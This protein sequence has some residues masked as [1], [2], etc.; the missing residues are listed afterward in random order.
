MLFVSGTASIV[1]HETLHAGDVVAQTRETLAK[2]EAVFAEA[3]RVSR[4]G[5]RHRAASL[6]VYVRHPQDAARVRR[7][8][9]AALGPAADA[10][11]LRADICRHDLLVEIEAIAYADAAGGRPG[12]RIARIFARR[13]RPAPASRAAIALAIAALACAAAHG[14]LRDEPLWEA[15]AGLAALYLPDYRGASQGRVYALPV[16]YFVYRGDFLKADRHGVRGGAFRNVAPNSTCRSAPRFPWTIAQSERGRHAQFAPDRGTGCVARLEPVASQGPACEGRSS[17][18][19]RGAVT[20][21]WHAR[22]TGARFRRHLN[23][24]VN[25]VAEFGGRTWASSAARCTPTGATTVSLHGRRRTWSATRPA[26][27]AR[28]GYGGVQ[29]VVALSRRFRD[30]GVGAYVRHDTPRGAVY[31]SYSPLWVA[32]PPRA[33]WG[34]HGVSASAR[35][36]DALRGSNRPCPCCTRQ[37]RSRTMLLPRS[38]FPLLVRCASCGRRVPCSWSCRPPGL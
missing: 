3:N 13:V 4:S 8:V 34:R 35:A 10:H 19:V 32:E 30:S 15:G 24:D 27:E 25:D 31:E 22:Y 23:L 14:Q 9:F 20:V 26:F 6:K 2:L 16:P 17:P 1:G 36:G 12:R 21:E 5:R 29:F 28:G 33:A 18:A 38:D 37:R 7:E 11:F